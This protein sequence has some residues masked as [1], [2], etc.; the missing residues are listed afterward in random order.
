MNSRQL[1]GI[2]LQVSSNTGI[3]AITGSE[4]YIL[5][6]LDNKYEETLAIIH[7]LIMVVRLMLHSIKTVIYFDSSKIKFD[8]ENNIEE[9]FS[10]YSQLFLALEKCFSN[11]TFSGVSKGTHIEMLRKKI[12]DLSIHNT[13]EITQGDISEIIQR[14]SEILDV[15]N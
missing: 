7:A 10:P 6:N 15:N 3:K 14:M 1:I 11:L 8:R 5:E 4:S 13:N 9:E 2:K 12:N